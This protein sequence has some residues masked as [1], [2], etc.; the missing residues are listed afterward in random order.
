VREDSGDWFLFRRSEDY[1]YKFYIGISLN[2]CLYSIFFFF[3]FKGNVWKE[4]CV[5]SVEFDN[6]K[7][8]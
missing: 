1:C 4:F 7:E 6:G 3:F 5:G 8:I 2:C